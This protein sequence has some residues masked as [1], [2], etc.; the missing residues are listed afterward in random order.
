MHFYLNFHL[1]F[2]N[3]AHPQRNDHFAWSCWTINQLLYQQLCTHTIL[4]VTSKSQILREKANI[5]ACAKLCKGRLSPLGPV[6][7][8]WLSGHSSELWNSFS[9]KVS[10]THTRTKYVDMPASDTF[11]ESNEWDVVFEWGM[12]TNPWMFLNELPS[13]PWHYIVHLKL[14]S[15]IT[16]VLV[17]KN[18]ED[19][20]LRQT[21]HGNWI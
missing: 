11:Y 17:Q 19:T 12:T 4:D 7:C 18:G 21:V 3:N 9:V 14:P 15:S 10:H 2:E 20:K 16:L 6:S 5:N 13:C 8:S 1:R